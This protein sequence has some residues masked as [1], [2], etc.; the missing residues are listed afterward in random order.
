MAMLIV[1]GQARGGG[2]GNREGRGRIGNR[3]GAVADTNHGYVSSDYGYA[4]DCDRVLMT[5]YY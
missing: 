2:K 1:S 4:C 5:D 3:V